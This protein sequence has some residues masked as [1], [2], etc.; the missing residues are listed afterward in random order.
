M[1]PDD[2]T[3]RWVFLQYAVM[4]SYETRRYFQVQVGVEAPEAPWP[5]ETANATRA[6]HGALLSLRV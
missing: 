4:T 6:A 3:Q 2:P 5:K 1:R